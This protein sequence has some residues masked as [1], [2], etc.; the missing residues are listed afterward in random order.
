MLIFKGGSGATMLKDMDQASRMLNMRIKIDV[1]SN[2][3][4]EN[5]REI[6]RENLRDLFCELP[7]RRVLYY[8]KHL[9]HLQLKGFRP[10]GDQGSRLDIEDLMDGPEDVLVRGKFSIM[11]EIARPVF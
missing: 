9:R 10:N 6:I 1:W 8:L 5:F 4:D 11:L 2:G 7:A 3:L